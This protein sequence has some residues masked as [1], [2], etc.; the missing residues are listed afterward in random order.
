MKNP[1]SKF[2]IRVLAVMENLTGTG[3]AW[4]VEICGV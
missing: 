1:G 2:T 3:F 4:D